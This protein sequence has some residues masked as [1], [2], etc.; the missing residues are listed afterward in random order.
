M[1]CCILNFFFIFIHLFLGTYPRH[2]PVHSCLGLKGIAVCI[3]I[4]LH[5]SNTSV[6]LSYVLGQITLMFKKKTLPSVTWADKLLIHIPTV[7]M[8]GVGDNPTYTPPQLTI[9]LLLP[10][11]SELPVRR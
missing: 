3:T 1:P 9:P 8:L 11:P 10:H 7:G 4:H 5:I 6:Y 2:K